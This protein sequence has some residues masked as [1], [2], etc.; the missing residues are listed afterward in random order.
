MK[1]VDCMFPGKIRIR[2]DTRKKILMACRESIPQFDRLNTF[3]VDDYC[4][5]LIEETPYNPRKHF[6][7]DEDT[8]VKINLKIFK[9]VAIEYLMEHIDEFIQEKYK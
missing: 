2:E 9:S 5:L 1:F 8:G 7:Y 6:F 3:R 4:N